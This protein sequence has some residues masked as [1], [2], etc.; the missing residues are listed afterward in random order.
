MKLRKT[1]NF[2]ET[3]DLSFLE[4][5]KFENGNSFP[6]SYKEFVHEYGYGLL[7]QLYLIYIPMGNYSDSW[8]IKSK[9]LKS[10]LLEIIDNDW[11]LTL[12]P[13]GYI[14][15]IKRAIPFGKSENGDILFWEDS[16]YKNNELNIFITNV[17]GAGVFF[18]GN[19][20]FDLIENMIVQ[21]KFKGSLFFSNYPLE[22]IFK[23][24]KKI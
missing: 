10:T 14:D 3:G 19:T 15:L 22:P 7:C 24:I 23:A 17:K 9:E 16:S 11:Y 5:Y 6:A 13:D 21:T 4:D 12:E 20:L 18:M 8:M 1:E 2:K